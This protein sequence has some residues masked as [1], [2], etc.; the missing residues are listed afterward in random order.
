[1]QT[2]E[3][4]TEDVTSGSAPAPGAP[5]PR[6]TVRLVRAPWATVIRTFAFVRKEIVEIV[7]QPR[8]VAVHQ[9]VVQDD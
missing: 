9:R 7:R 2:H 5:A 1:M 8:L 3:S 6:R 4:H